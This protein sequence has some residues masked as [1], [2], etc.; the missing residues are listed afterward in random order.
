MALKGT[1]LGWVG[2]RLS[3]RGVNILLCSN[4]P[5][6][7][8]E[9]SHKMAWMRIYRYNYAKLDFDRKIVKRIGSLVG[10][11]IQ[12]LSDHSNREH[13]LDAHRS[14]SPPKCGC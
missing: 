10:I 14:H 2:M 4:F 8:A 3:R 11:G 12:S 5:A 6:I 7:V 1:V 9:T 13:C